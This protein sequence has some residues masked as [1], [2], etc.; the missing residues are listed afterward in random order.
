MAKI[1]SNVDRE[2][3]PLTV[4][5]EFDGQTPERLWQLWADREQVQG[6]WGPPGYPATFTRHDF[7]VPGRSIYYMESP[8]G[9]RFY[10]WWSLLEL[11]EP[12]RLRIE[13]GFGDSEGNPAPD[14]PDAGE[15][16]IDIEATDAGARFSIR[17]QF[18]TLEQLEELITMGQEEGMVQAMGQI[19]GILAA[20]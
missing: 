10:G 18:A 15:M 9:E 5:A 11:S 7:T 1:T 17:S 16:V 8:E 3:L 13:D 6:W 14:M 12:S 19:E 4:S 20:S 2:N